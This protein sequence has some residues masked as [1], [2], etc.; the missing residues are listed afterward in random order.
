MFKF[1]RFRS[2][3]DVYT[4]TRSGKQELASDGISSVNG[5]Y[6]ISR[7]EF[8]SKFLIYKL[9]SCSNTLNHKTYMYYHKH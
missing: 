6:R 8:S 7:N 2:N 5:A 9:Y 4:A 1:G 3:F